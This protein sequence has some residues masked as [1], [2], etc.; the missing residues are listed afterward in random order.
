M[1][2]LH[3]YFVDYQNCGSST[4]ACCTTFD[5][6]IC[7]LVLPHSYFLFVIFFCVAHENLMHMQT[8][9]HVSGAFFVT[10]IIFL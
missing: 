6:N 10:V 7:G 1:V 2:F 3:L 5:E 8:H 4:T 9:A